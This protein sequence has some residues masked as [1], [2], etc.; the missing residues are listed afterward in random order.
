MRLGDAAGEKEPDCLVLIGP[1]AVR[2]ELHAS[3]SR[4]D[5]R[6]FFV[7][8]SSDECS[9]RKGAFDNDAGGSERIVTRETAAVTLV[10][11]RFERCDLKGRLCVRSSVLRDSLEQGDVLSQPGG[12]VMRGARSTVVGIRRYYNH[13][14]QNAE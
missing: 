10:R 7:Y 12:S 8:R 11:K 3:I 9:I 6:G 14:Q 1:R 13:P 4:K 5:K 2:K